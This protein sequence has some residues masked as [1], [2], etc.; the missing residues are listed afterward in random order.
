MKRLWF[1]A[2]ASNTKKLIRIDFIVKTYWVPFSSLIKNLELNS[3]HAMC[4]L[5]WTHWDVGMMGNIL[6]A[7]MFG[8]NA[9]KGSPCPIWKGEY[10]KRPLLSIIGVLIHGLISVNICLDH[11]WCNWCSKSFQE[12][13]SLLHEQLEC[14]AVDIILLVTGNK[15]FDFTSAF[16]QHSHLR[17][18]NYKG[19]R[20]Q[21]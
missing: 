2:F 1:C 7:P 6:R 21:Y 9:N 13:F 17:V 5:S 4:A 12:I 18:P 14:K 15:S 3:F 20:K 16:T 8:Y 10:V 19:L 11:R